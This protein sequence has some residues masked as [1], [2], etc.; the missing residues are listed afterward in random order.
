LKL[1]GV[2][3][4]KADGTFGED[5][6][7]RRSQVSSL[8]V[9]LLQASGI[10]LTD[11]SSFP[12]VDTSTVPNSQVRDE[13]ERLAGAGIIAGFPDG[14]F[15]P[16]S[17]LTVAQAATL[18]VRTM[19]FIHAKNHASPDALDQGSTGANYAYAIQKAL[20][21][22]NAVD[23]N[24]VGYPSQMGDVTD[25]GLLA[26]CLAQAIQQLVA[27]GVVASRAT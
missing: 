26:D 13:I 25:R 22:P 8:L 19:A 17:N 27:S 16:A 5:D 10:T 21:D 7:L 15:K 24:G 23:V 20:L 12:D 4:G 2:A 6:P 14:T 18:V 11:T 9:R 1:Y 3:L